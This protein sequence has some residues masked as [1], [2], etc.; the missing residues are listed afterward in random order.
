MA[1]VGITEKLSDLLLL[2]D[3]GYEEEISWTVNQSFRHG[4]SFLLLVL[5]SLIRK[6]GEFLEE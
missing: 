2:S 6:T 5:V 3:T 1:G 4:N